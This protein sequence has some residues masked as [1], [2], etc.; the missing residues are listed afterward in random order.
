LTWLAKTGLPRQC[1]VRPL[2]SSPARAIPQFLDWASPYAP[3]VLRNLARGTD[4]A[5]DH[6]ILR[7]QLPLPEETPLRRDGSPH[8]A[9]WVLQARY[10]ESETHYAAQ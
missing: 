1:T 3:T 9:E 4:A 2:A 6:M 10:R 7:E 8:V 5:T